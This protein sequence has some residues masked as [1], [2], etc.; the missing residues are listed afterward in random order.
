MTDAPRSV[1]GV[2]LNFRETM[3]RLAPSLH[4]S[5][6]QRPPQGPILYLKTPNTWIQN[7]Q[8]IPCPA[9][10]DRLRMAGTLGVVIAS[11]ACNINAERAFDYVAG[12]CVAN[13]VSIPHDSFYRPKLRERC[14]DGFCSIGAP[15]DRTAQT[16]FE[17]KVFVNGELH[18]LASTASFIR[19]IAHLIQDTSEFMTLH[20]GDILLVG[21]PDNSPLAAPGDAVRVEIA[22]VGSI[23]NKVVLEV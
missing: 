5:P 2:A 21:E 12:F 15:V 18:S 22:G 1:I 9:G 23:E 11:T 20:A 7:G 6:Y 19:D 10:V 4:V 13:D 8:P 16:T 3:D 17:I 14:S